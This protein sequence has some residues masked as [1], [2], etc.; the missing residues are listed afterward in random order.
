LARAFAIGKEDLSDLPVDEL[1]SGRDKT[2]F[3][4]SGLHS[5]GA[6]MKA[7][8]AEPAVRTRMTGGVNWWYFYGIARVERLALIPSV[9][10]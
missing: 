7:Q 2:R 10:K 6:P 9:R 1:A 4:R 5:I 8:S 3:R